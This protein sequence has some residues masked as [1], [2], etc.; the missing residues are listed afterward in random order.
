[1]GMV[2]AGNAAGIC[3]TRS[4]NRM[5]SGISESQRLQPMTK[6][7]LLA[8]TKRVAR[9]KVITTELDTCSETG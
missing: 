4:A 2:G 9:E 1:M 3:K 7:I 8:L 6:E 5:Q